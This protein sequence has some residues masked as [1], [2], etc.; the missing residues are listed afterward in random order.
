[1]TI[2]RST[3]AQASM[4]GVIP[5]ARVYTV[6][7][8]KACGPACGISWTTSGV[9]AN[10]SCTCVSRATS[11]STTLD[12]CT[13]VRPSKQPCGAS[14]RPRASIGGGWPINIVVCRYRSATDERSPKFNSRGLDIL[15]PGR[16]PQPVIRAGTPREVLVQ[17][18]DEL[19]GFKDVQV[20][21]MMLT[22]TDRD[23]FDN[24]LLATWADRPQAARTYVSVTAAGQR[25]FGGR[26]ETVRLDFE[27]RFEEVRTMLSPI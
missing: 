17:I 27:G 14:S 26:Q 9:S 10:A 6:A 3:M 12:T 2:G 24:T 20:A 18:W 5:T 7:R 4:R 13:G 22:V 1:M 21:E 11:S 25:E 8:W 23:S 15:R 19:G 16:D